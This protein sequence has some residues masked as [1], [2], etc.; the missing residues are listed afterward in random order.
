MHI[1]KLSKSPFQIELG[2]LRLKG[3]N[4]LHMRIAKSQHIQAFQR[5]NKIKRDGVLLHGG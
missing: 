1:D 3:R 5:G 2:E 4:G